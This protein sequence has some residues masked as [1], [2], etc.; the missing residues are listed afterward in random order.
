MQL[1]AVKSGR[2]VLIAA[3]AGALLAI[4]SGIALVL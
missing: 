1:R 4:G 3:I 2:R